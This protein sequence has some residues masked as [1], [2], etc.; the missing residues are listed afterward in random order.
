MLTIAANAPPDNPQHAYFAAFMAVLGSTFGNLALF[1]AAR[2][3]SR[4]F[5]KDSTPSPRA[6]K[7]QQWFDRYGMLTVFVPCV[8]PVI[9]FP[10]KVFVVSAGALRTR[11]S[12]LF[13]WCWWR[14]SSA[15][16]GEAWLGVNLGPQ[17]EAFL[18]RNAWTLLGIALAMTM[19]SYLAIR[20]N[21]RRRASVL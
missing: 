7:F 4:K 18:K 12:S 6:A 10:L 8:V 9:P 19:G 16:S 17:A 3:G 21:E 11:I 14:A 2:H 13:W 5:T 15:T 20:W 1:W